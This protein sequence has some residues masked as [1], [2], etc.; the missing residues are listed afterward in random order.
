MEGSVDTQSNNFVASVFSFPKHLFLPP[1]TMKKTEVS[2]INSI[3]WRSRPR[4]RDDEQVCVRYP[5]KDGTLM[6]R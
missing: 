6:W 1:N 5:A 3:L 2:N 4:S